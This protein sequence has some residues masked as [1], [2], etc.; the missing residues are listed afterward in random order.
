MKC[1]TLFS[2]KIEILI[3]HLLTLPRV[4]TICVCL[5]GGGVERSCDISHLK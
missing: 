3:G 5:C 1:Q 2:G 4:L